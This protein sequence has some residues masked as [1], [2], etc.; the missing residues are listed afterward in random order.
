MPWTIRITGLADGSRT[1]CDG[2]YLFVFMPNEFFGRGRIITTPDIEHAMS[3]RTREEALAFR[4][5]VP[6]PPW[7][8]RP[9][10][11]PNRPLT[12]LEIEI[13]WRD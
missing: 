9:D 1:V 4:A 12:A 6:D 2:Q 10:G 5:Q 3:F 8:V 13:V 11:E 7:D